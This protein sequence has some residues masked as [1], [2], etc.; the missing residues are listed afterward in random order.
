MK[1]F[2]VIL[3]SLLILTE[4]AK[5]QEDPVS[6]FQVKWANSKPYLLTIAKKMPAKH[7]DFKPTDRQMSFKDQLLHI[8]ENMLKLSHAYIDPSQTFQDTIDQ[9]EDLNKAQT[10]RL[11]GEAFEEVEDIVG[12]VEKKDLATQVDFFEGTKTKLQIL[13]LVQDHVTHHR[14]QIIVYL[15]LKGFKPPEYVGW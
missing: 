9:P 1:K 6:A 13:N 4:F 7:Y 14:G 2:T 11:L 12:E 5:S 15:N 10:I 3:F 8:R